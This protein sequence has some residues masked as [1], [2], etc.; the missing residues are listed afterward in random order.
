MRAPLLPDSSPF[1]VEVLGASWEL[2]EGRIQFRQMRGVGRRGM[3]GHRP[4]SRSATDG[5]GRALGRRGGL[6]LAPHSSFIEHASRGTGPTPPNPLS[7]LA[8]EAR[9]PPSTDAVVS[10]RMDLAPLAF[11]PSLRPPSIP[12]PLSACCPVWGMVT[13]A[14]PCT[15]GA[16]PHTNRRWLHRCSSCSCDSPL[17]YRSLL[18]CPA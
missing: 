9:S 12:T 5:S 8:R 13:A 18:R 4:D 10:D 16:R 11:A 14:P 2:P 6:P 17:R 1:R 7:T 3:G 15:L